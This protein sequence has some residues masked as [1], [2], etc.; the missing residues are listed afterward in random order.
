MQLDTVVEE[1]RSGFAHA[2]THRVIEEVTGDHDHLCP[3]PSPG[4][5][6]LY[7]AYP[8]ELIALIPLV[9]RVDDRDVDFVPAGLNHGLVMGQG[10]HRIYLRAVSE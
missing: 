5:N 3:D 4:S 10:G 9:C 6:G 1:V 7:D 8:G 2:P